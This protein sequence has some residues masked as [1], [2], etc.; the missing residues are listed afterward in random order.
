ME[1]IVY[2]CEIEFFLSSQEELT[3]HT[4]LIWFDSSVRLHTNN[5]TFTKETIV[6]TNGIAL[7][8]TTGHSTYAVTHPDMYLYLPIHQKPARKEQRAMTA[9]ALYRTKTVIEDIMFWLL[10][11]S[12]DQNCIAPTWRIFCTF[13]DRFLEYAGCHRFDQSAMN[14]ILLNLYKHDNYIFYPE[15][16]TG[17]SVQR[18]ET[19]Y[20]K[21][22]ICPSN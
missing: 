5:L 17:V 7:L 22:K 14:I 12:L 18:M 6:N 10:L 8:T 21:L 16:Q 19:K 15:K 13:E 3:T 9:I 20:F 1:H 4:G 2:I 11:C